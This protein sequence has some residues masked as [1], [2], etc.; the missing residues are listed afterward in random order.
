MANLGGAYEAGD[1]TMGERDALPAGEYVAALVKSDRVEAKSGN[2]N[3]YINCEF[4]VQDG[5]KQG[6]RFWTLLN[7]WNNNSTAVDIAQRELNSMMHACGKLRVEDTEELHGIPMLVKLKVKTD[8][9]YGDKNEVASYKPMNAGS[10]GNF[11][12][13]QSQASGGADNSSAPWKRSA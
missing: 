10:G 1:E 8:A 6:R 3:A 7:L 9:Q 12:G 5:E 13:Q 4:E 11:G 2:G